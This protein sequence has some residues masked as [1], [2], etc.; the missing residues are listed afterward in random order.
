MDDNLDNT[1]KVEILAEM[2]NLDR[3]KSAELVETLAKMLET[4]L[5]EHTSIKRAGWFMSKTRPVAELSVQFDS[6]GYLIE[7]TKK[8]SISA[9]QQKI[10][11]G[12]ALKSSEIPLEDCMAQIVEELTSLADK[13]STARMALN[14]FLEGRY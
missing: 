3:Q 9:K 7:R 6:V 11:R 1:L 12:I 14:H 4:A 10:V 13:S 5:P 2:L 8:G